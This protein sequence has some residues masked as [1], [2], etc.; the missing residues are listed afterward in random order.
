MID[1]H[2]QPSRQAMAGTASGGH[3]DAAG[4]LA[5]RKVAENAT[6]LTIDQCLTTADASIELK[7]L[8][9]SDSRQH[10]TSTRESDAQSTHDVSFG[11]LAG[12][13]RLR[14]LLFCAQRSTCPH[15]VRTGD[16][17]SERR[18]THPPGS[19]LQRR[20]CYSQRRE[21]SADVC[22]LAPGFDPDARAHDRT[23]RTPRSRPD[24]HRA[25]VAAR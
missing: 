21:Y 22:G 12:I 7:H 23:D 1:R 3:P 2:R 9:P 4:E 13:P 18:L 20:L 19:I 17:S 5:V 24:N 25:G 6:G 8:E 14:H 16:S 10:P 11:Q 15:T